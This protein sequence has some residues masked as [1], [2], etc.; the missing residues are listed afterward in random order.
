MTEAAGPILYVAMSV[1]ANEGGFPIGVCDSL[2]G[3]RKLCQDGYDEPLVW[4]QYGC[5]NSPTGGGSLYYEVRAFMLNGE[6]IDPES[7]AP[8]SG[9]S[10]TEKSST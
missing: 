8:Q 2:A 7:G 10:A 9:E 1:T 5:A 4:D 3:A 6:E